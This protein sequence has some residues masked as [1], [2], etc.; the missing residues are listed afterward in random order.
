MDSMREGEG[1]MVVKLIWVRHKK[2]TLILTTRHNVK[3]IL[4]EF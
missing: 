1:D 2:V 4:K 3:S